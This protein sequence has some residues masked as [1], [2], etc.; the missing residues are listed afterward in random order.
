MAFPPGRLSSSAPSFKKRAKKAREHPPS[1][2]V[3]EKTPISLESTT[4]LPPKSSQPVRIEK[5][6]FSKEREQQKKLLREVQILM[7]M[8]IKLF[9]DL[10]YN[11][12]DL[13]EGMAGV[14]GSDLL[15]KREFSVMGI[16]KRV[17]I[18]Q[19]LTYLNG[20]GHK[21][22]PHVEA[23]DFNS[24]AM[25]RVPVPEGKQLSSIQ[26]LEGKTRKGRQVFAALVQRSDYQGSYLFIMK[27]SPD[28]F[29]NNEGLLDR[30]LNSIE[31]MP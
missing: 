9:E 14:Y 11:P 12:L 30:L 6:L 20:E 10:H 19:V 16:E 28:F 31:V 24:R 27:E 3:Q 17:D 2:E 22:L 23:G 29:N 1:P 26:V 5:T 13:E 4:D 8:K 18:K 25:R 15:K 21:I 7:R